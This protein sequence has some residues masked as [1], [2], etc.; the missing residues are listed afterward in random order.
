MKNQALK[1]II[2]IHETIADVYGNRYRVAIVINP[3][4]WKRCKART[5]SAGN[6]RYITSALLEGRVYDVTVSTGSARLSSLPQAVHMDI[7]D[8]AR[9]LRQIGYNIPAAR[10]EGV[11]GCL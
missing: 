10:V 1:A 5:C 3:K 6:V 2:E 7:A 11:Q 8:F 9:A 4:N